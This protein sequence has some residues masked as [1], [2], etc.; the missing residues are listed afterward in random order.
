[1]KVTSA[2]TIHIEMDED[3]HR[4]LLLAL[5]DTLI[6]FNQA[7]DANITPAKDTLLKFKTE[8]AG[9]PR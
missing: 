1:M 8:L 6:V 7:I 4:E 9:A 5:N 2:R 3:E